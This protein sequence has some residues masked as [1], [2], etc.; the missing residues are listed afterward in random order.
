MDNSPEPS[1]LR[2]RNATFKAIDIVYP[3]P[4]VFLCGLH[5]DDIL[6]GKVLDLTECGEGGAQCA[7]IEVERGGCAIVPIDRIIAVL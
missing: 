6:Q 7:V 2:S 4:G 1:E 3:E 5:G